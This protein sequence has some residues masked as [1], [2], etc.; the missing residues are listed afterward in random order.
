MKKSILAL[1][2]LALMAWG[3]SSSDDD[4][5]QGEGLL[6]G[7]E[8]RP[9]WQVPNFDNYEQTMTV[10]VVLQ[11]T[12]QG[13]ASAADLLCATIDEEVRGVAVPRL[14]DNRWRFV[15]TIASNEAGKAITLLYYCDEL[16]RI[17]SVDWGTFDA[18]TPPT[19][20]GGLYQPAFVN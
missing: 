13:Y 4:P 14:V 3:C 9:A 2:A 17:F 7:T 19:G 16:H 10:A 18:N 15:L 20:E 12:L 11:D 5:T 6:G 1:A 8:A